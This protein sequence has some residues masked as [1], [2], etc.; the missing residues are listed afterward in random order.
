MVVGIQWPD[1]MRSYASLCEKLSN[2]SLDRVVMIHLQ[3]SMGR[4]GKLP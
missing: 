4:C 3:A 1:S 2:E